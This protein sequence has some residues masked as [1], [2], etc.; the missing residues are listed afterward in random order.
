LSSVRHKAQGLDDDESFIPFWTGLFA[1]SDFISF[2]LFT[3]ITDT[4]LVVSPV[5]VSDDADI[6]TSALFDVSTKTGSDL[7]CS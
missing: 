5:L 3:S 1:L 2:S 4:F 7:T 6:S